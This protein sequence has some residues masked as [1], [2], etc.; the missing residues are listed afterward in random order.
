ME[1]DIVQAELTAGV[2][3]IEI[4][5]GR[6]EGVAFW[7]IYQRGGLTREG[8]TPVAATPVVDVQREAEAA[9]RRVVA[10]RREHLTAVLARLDELGE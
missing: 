8:S 5:T 10:E 6:R 2:F 7:S 3:Q 4:E 1:R 9:M